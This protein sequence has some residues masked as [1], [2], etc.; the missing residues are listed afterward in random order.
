MKVHIKVVSEESH[1]ED[2]AYELRS[3][4]EA[5]VEDFVADNEDMSVARK[6]LEEIHG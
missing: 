1:E 4:L 5:A 2:L 6:T 3:V